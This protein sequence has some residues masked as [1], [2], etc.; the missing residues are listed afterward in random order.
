LSGTASSSGLTPEER[1]E[2][3]VQLSLR[4]VTVDYFGTVGLR[5]EG[6]RLFDARDLPGAPPVMIVSRR[7]ADLAWPGQDPI[8]RRG[9][10]CES[11]LDRGG[12]VWRTVVGVVPDVRS[13]VA[14]TDLKPQL[15]LPLR[16]ASLTSWDL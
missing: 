8:G 1:Q 16:Q 11:S 14:T 10:C 15:Y 7:L 3:R 6:G 13:G 12:P 9:S 2:E 5:R 4:L